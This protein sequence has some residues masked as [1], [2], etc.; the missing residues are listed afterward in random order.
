MKNKI[1]ALSLGI[2]FVVVMVG[3]FQLSGI[4]SPISAVL[5]SQNIAEWTKYSI[6]AFHEVMLVL[7]V[8]LALICLIKRT[9]IVTYDFSSMMLIQLPISVVF[10]KDSALFRDF[11][12]ELILNPYIIASL[13]VTSFLMFGVVAGYKRDIH[14]RQQG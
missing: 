3:V 14:F 1:T 10:F 11:T 7:A 12:P 4:Y 2:F 8:F 13:L 5:L 9:T 6:F